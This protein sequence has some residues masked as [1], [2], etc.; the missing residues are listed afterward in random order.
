MILQYKGFTGMNIFLDNQGTQVTFVKAE[1]Q[2][3]EEDQMKSPQLNQ[4]M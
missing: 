2:W 1:E 4:Q 3:N